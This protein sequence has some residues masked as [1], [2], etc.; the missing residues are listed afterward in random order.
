MKKLD[1]VNM[2][3]KEIGMTPVGSLDDNHP[4]VESALAVMN[5]IH[6]SKLLRGWW[7]NVDYDVTLTP[8]N[9]LSHITFSNEIRTAVPED[10]TLVKRDRKLYDTVNNT[11]V[12]AGPQVMKTLTRIVAWDE[13]DS[14][15]QDYIAYLSAAQFVR[16][17]LE[18]SAKETSLK[19]DAQQALVTLTDLD[20]EMGQYN[21]FDNARVRRARGGVRPYRGVIQ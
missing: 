21:V 7:F 1:T 20:L 8:D 12:F 17:E 18:D 10:C 15:F 5:R 3:L 2:L 13:C 9:T 4:D 11:Y 19:E 6:N 14:S 16:E